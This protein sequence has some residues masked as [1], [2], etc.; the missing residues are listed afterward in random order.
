ML[1]LTHQGNANQSCHFTPVRMA[2]TN[3]TRNNRCWRGCGEK[4]TRRALLVGMQT[5]AATV[6]GSMEA[7]H[8]VRNRT[9]LHP[10]IAL[11]GIYPKNTKTLI[12]RDTR[13]LAFITALLTVAKIWK[14]PKCPSI[15]ECVKRCGIYIYIYTHTHTRLLFSHKKEWN[16]A[17]L[18]WH[19]WS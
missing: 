17:I 19:G 13:T 9:T 14:Q 8:K 16:L 5:G 6:E 12:Q 1:N 2:K 15:D 3:N 11:Q 7:P 4:G 18:Q 10:A